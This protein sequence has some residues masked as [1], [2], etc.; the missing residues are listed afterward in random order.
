MKIAL[1]GGTHGNEPVGI[2]VMKYFK[3]TSETFENQFKCFWG[4]PKAYELKRRYVDFDLNRSFGKNTKTHF[5][6]KV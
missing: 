5:K 4:N 1:V 6:E 2:E 3:E